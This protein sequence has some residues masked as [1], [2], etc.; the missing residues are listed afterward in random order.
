MPTLSTGAAA[1]D[2]AGGGAAATGTAPGLRTAAS[3]CRGI[4]VRPVATA[5]PATI[6][7]T[8]RA[9]SSR[10]ATPASARRTGARGS[11]NPSTRG[12][13]TSGIGATPWLIGDAP[14]SWATSHDHRTT[15]TAPSAH[16]DMAGI[17]P[18]RP[19]RPSPDQAEPPQELGARDRHGDGRSGSPLA[20]QTPQSLPGRQCSC[21]GA[22]CPHRQERASAAASAVVS[23][24]PRHCGPGRPVGAPALCGG[25]AASPASSRDDAGFRWVE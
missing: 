1:T 25:R 8:T 10:R 22:P 4:S 13:G 15:R 12:T 14:Q 5:A 19:D 2:R 23:G 11:V 21:A 18:V 24:H 20:P 7:T 6:T 3:A 16:P 9:A 17:A